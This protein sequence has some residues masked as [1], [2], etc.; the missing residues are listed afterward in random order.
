MISY[1]IFIVALFLLANKSN[2]Q[3]TATSPWEVINK[4]LRPPL[5]EIRENKCQIVAG[6]YGFVWPTVWLLNAKYTSD[7]EY[8]GMA[9][10]SDAT[11]SLWVKAIKNGSVMCVLK[12]DVSSYSGKETLL[13]PY[14]KNLEPLRVTKTHESENF[15]FFKH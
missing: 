15:L 12:N 1:L 9:Y 13:V 8:Y 10:R 4:K 6:N 11:R 3:W 14:T 5:E 2:L 7:P